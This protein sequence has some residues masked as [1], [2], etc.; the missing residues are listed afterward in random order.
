MAFADNNLDEHERVFRIT[1][2]FVFNPTQSESKTKR[3]IAI[4]KRLN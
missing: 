1:K 3:E 4:Y 2:I